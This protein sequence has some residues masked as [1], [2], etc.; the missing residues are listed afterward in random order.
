MG[1]DE[2]MEDGGVVEGV[3]EVVLEVGGSVGRGDEGVEVWEG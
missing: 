2:G 3:G 1:E